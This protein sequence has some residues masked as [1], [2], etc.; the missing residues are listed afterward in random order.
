MHSQDSSHGTRFKPGESG[1]PSGRPKGSRNKASKFVELLDEH[2]TAV[3]EKFVEKAIEG[4]P[5]AL[6]LYI[7]RLIP[8]RTGRPID[9]E[10]PEIKTATD[11]ATASKIVI[12]AV[13]DGTVTLEE[14]SKLINLIESHS[15]LLAHA[16]LE[17]RVAELEGKLAHLND[18]QARD[19]E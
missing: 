3:L 2:G 11:A 1:N 10:L 6:K 17:A 14:G 13:S 7:P 8:R 4:D 15:K 18:D 12:M 9:I 19:G 16:D 5:V